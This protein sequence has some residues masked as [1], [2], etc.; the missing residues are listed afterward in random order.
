V[1]GLKPVLYRV[2]AGLLALDSFALL[3]ASRAEWSTRRPA[4]IQTAFPDGTITSK[5]IYGDG[6][7]ERREAGPNGTTESI[8]PGT[9]RLCTQQ[10]K[11]GV[12]VG[13]CN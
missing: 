12:D 1:R 6:L 4:S 11:G 3:T 13:A 8:R 7:A 2:S 10:V 9:V 5:D